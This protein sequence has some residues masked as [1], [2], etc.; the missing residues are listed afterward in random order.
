[1][2]AN[3]EG[4]GVGY[5]SYLRSWVYDRDLDFANEFEHLNAE[6]FGIGRKARNGYKRLDK[7]GMIGNPFSIGPA[8][9]WFPGY[10]LASKILHFKTGYEPGLLKVVKWEV[11]I[12]GLLGVILVFLFLRKYFSVFPSVFSVFSI[13][14]AS[15]LFYYLRNNPFLSHVPSF[16]SVS[17][18]LYLLSRTD[19][20]RGW[21]LW[22]LIGGACGLSFLVRWQNGLLLFIPVLWIYLNLI[23]KEMIPRREILNSTFNLFLL[24]VSFVAVALPQFLVFKLLYGSFFTVPQGKKFVTLPVYLLDS[25]FSPFHG[26]FNWH[27]FLLLALVGFLFYWRKRPRLNAVALSGF[28]LEALVNGS[29]RQFWAGASF[30]AR[31][32]VGSLPFLSVGFSNLVSKLN[33]KVKIFFVFLLNLFFF[34]NFFAEIFYIRGFIPA[35]VPFGFWEIL[36]SIYKNFTY[37]HIKLLIFFILY[38]LAL[39]VL[40]IRTLNQGEGT[41]GPRP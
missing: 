2:K 35:E 4:D 28:S 8:I 29:L 15:P 5:F 33:K 11:W 31:R 26:L 30:G 41:T 19:K 17:L 40:L 38:L 10:Y 25:L 37:L 22:V 1:M 14:L 39:N 6:K 20:N 18:F 34:F 3:V 13:L 12:Y 23:K 7:T 24:V 21:F 9:L 27:P 32:Y 36:N 16:F